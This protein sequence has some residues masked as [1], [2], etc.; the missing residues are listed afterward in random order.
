MS[1]EKK[2]APFCEALTQNTS[3]RMCA[4]S[5]FFKPSK[6]KQNRSKHKDWKLLYQF[7]GGWWE[8]THVPT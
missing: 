5:T 2:Y 7:L 8:E 4:M 3:V 1:Q 6:D